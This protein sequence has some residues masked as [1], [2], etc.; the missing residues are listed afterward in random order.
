MTEIK[1]FWIDNVPK[2]EDIEK[3]FSLVNEWT[4][5]SILWYVKYNGS[6][7]RIITYDIKR[8]YTAEEFFEDCIPHVY[9]V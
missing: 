6:H 3:A 4:C 8:K 5:V 9:G 7:E 2:L 1:S